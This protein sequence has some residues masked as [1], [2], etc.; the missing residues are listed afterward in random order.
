M[1]KDGV[2]ERFID[3]ARKGGAQFVAHYYTKERELT[4]EDKKYLFGRAP[5]TDGLKELI[6]TSKHP[7]I[8]KLDDRFK[9][10]AE[11]FTKEWVGF[12][13]KNQLITWIEANFKGHAPDQ[14]IEDWLK[15]KAIPWK[16]GNLTRRIQTENEGRPR[17]YLLI[18]RPERGC[19]LTE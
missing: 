3:W 6:E 1:D 12:I 14:E 18:D 13:S 5:K 2:F 8:K 11:P 15:E 19:N 16:D 17:V 7:T 9:D 10:E 4:K